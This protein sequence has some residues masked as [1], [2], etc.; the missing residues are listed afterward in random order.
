[1]N[2]MLLANRGYDADC[3]RDTLQEKDI[4]PRIPG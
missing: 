1:M 4:K 3:F 2:T